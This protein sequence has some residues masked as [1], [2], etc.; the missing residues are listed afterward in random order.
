M[1]PTSLRDCLSQ[2]D[3]R[4]KRPGIEQA[5]CNFYLARMLRRLVL[6]FPSW[7]GMLDTVYE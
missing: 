2:F 4:R 6:N 1:N 5:V 7:L 3:L